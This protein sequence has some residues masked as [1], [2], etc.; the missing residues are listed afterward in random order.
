MEFRE[1]V[2]KKLGKVIDPG[3]NMDIVSM[4]LIKNIKIEDDG[5]VSLEFHPSSPVCPLV[6]SLAIKI[7]ESML[8][9]NELKNVDIFLA[10]GCP[11]GLDFGREPDHAVP[12]IREILDCVRPHY[13]FCG[14]GHFFKQVVH[15]GCRIYSL[16]LASRAYY[17]L[18]TETDTFSAHQIDKTRFPVIKQRLM[19]RHER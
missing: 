4:G 18:D 11:S 8:S 1:I 7:K 9:I 14:H 15:D 17:T 10:H 12:A 2:L 5:N 3:T 13:M 16:D 6:Y 19:C